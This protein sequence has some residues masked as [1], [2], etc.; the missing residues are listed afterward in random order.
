[1]LDVCQSVMMFHYPTSHVPYL[2]GGNSNI[3]LISPLGKWCNSTTE[4]FFQI[5]WFNNQLDIIWWLYV[6]STPQTICCLQERQTSRIAFRFPRTA[7][8]AF[9]GTPGDLKQCSDALAVSWEEVAFIWSPPFLESSHG[10]FWNE[11]SAR[12]GAP[13]RANYKGNKR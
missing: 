8:K 5:G 9:Y 3:F 7:P 2:G 6:A 4:I 12:F 10:D 13:R 1:M 11:C